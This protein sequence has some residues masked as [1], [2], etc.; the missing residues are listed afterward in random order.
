[1][2]R[3]I[4]L[5]LL[6]CLVPI[7]ILAQSIVVSSQADFDALDVRVRQ[8]IIAGSKDILVQFSPGTYFFQEEHLNLM[9]IKQPGL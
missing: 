2:K 9:G 3:L 6:S 1:M 8:L 7:G 4:V 5:L